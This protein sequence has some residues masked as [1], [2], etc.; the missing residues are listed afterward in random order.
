VAEIAFWVVLIGSLWSLDLLTKLDD[1]ARNGRGDEVTNAVVILEQASSGIAALLMVAFVVI[2]V[3]QFPVVQGQLLRST[4]GHL[5]GS[6]LFAFGHLALM[7]LLRIALLPIFLERRYVWWGDPVGNLIFE[8]Q[9]DV[10]IYVGMV[11]CLTIY[12]FWQK[13]RADH[14]GQLPQR[15]VV[16]TGRGSQFLEF[17]DIEC[18]TAARNY[19]SVFTAEREYVVRE[20]LANLARR[21]P[22]A[23]FVRN[24]RSHIVNLG[25]I[26][27]LH[28]P[29]SA[30]QSLR[31]DSGRELPVGRSFS[32]DLLESMANSYA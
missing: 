20:T 31:L 21:L 29:A 1:R 14:T 10:K 6:V 28:G 30:P 4:A 17:D 8:Y 11:A 25:R 26:A 23:Q 12:Y 27:E 2:W 9:K 22:A 19:V 7:V 32:Q 16:Q 13:Q 5:A 18:L 3:R 24:H 15:L